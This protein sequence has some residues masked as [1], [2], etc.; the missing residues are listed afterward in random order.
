MGRKNAVAAILQEIGLFLELRGENPFKSR[1]YYN[2]ARTVEQMGEGELLQ[3]IREDKLK[4]VPGI[5]AALNEKI[6]ELVL[7]GTLSYYEELKQSMPEGLLDLLKVPGLGPRKIKALHD[8]L[9]ITSLAELEYACKEN[10]LVNLKG[11]GARTQDNIISGIDYLRKSQGQYYYGEAKQLALA[12]LQEIR[13]FPALGELS[14][15]GSIRRCKE[16]V[17]DIDLVASSNDPGTL[18]RLFTALPQVMEIV[19]LG[20]TKATVRLTQGIN[21]DLRVVQT[22]EFP[23][24]LHHFTG[25][26]EHNT[27]LRH[28]ARQMGLK[29]NEYGVFRGEERILCRDE[30]DLFQTLELAYIPPELRENYGEIE[31]AERGALPCLVEESDIKGVFHVHTRYSDGENS[32][33]QV[34]LFCRE[35]GFEYVGISDHSQS[36]FYAGGLKEDDLKRQLAEITI[37]Q[38]K[39]PELKIFCGVESDIRSDG[40]L[41]YAD[42]LLQQLDFVI[43]S[44]HS[45]LNMSAPKMTERLLKALSHPRVTMLGHPTGR[46][47]L[48]RDG[49]PL[50]LEAVLQAA[51]QNN[52]IIELNASPARLDLD[53]RHLKRAREMGLL[54]S[55]NPDAHRLEEIYDTNLGVAM[56]RKGW[57]EKK[58]VFNTLTRREVELY[59]ESRKHG[60]NIK[61]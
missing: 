43:A 60:K 31:A 61:E 55:I 22:A 35:A 50:D 18:T 3:L 15:A 10:R 52:V 7:T 58:N 23:Y 14:L 11:F 13:N 51:R 1:A 5:G 53:W 37:L 8:S 30:T 26:K 48:G 49:Y 40:S 38:Q 36:A 42:E 32:L 54:V 56:A 29:V 39:Y 20:D 27:A 44:I 25:S 17:K 2:G 21:T 33:E 12:L 19:A 24:A 16:I 45:G 34:V 57:L 59:F 4:E 9:G 28:R 46:L 47:L 6:K 41:D